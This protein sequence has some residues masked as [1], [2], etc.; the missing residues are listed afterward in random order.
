MAADSSK[1]LA[2]AARSATYN[3]V[4]QVIF[5][6]TTF[7]LNAF[8][9]RYIS[10]E[11]L[12]VVNVRL[13]LLYSTTLFVAR[14][15]FRKAC[16]SKTSNAKWMQII[17]LLW[18]TVLLGLACGLSLAYFWVYFLEVPNPETI[19][20]YSVGVVVY[21]LSA[22][23]EL[24]AEPLYVIAQV[25]LFVKL[26]VIVEGLAV[27]FRSVLTVI[28]VL[29]FPHWGIITFCWAQLAFTILYVV[30]YYAYFI[31]Y[32]KT[33]GDKSFPLK[34]TRDIFPKR[35]PGHKWTDHTLA[36]L[37]WSFFKQGFMKQ[38]LTEG[39]RYIM[40][41]FGTINFSEQGVYDII[42]NLGSLAARFI[43]FPLEDS[44]YLFFAQTLERGIPVKDQPKK[45]MDL[46]SKV[47]EYLLGFVFIIGLTIAVF[48]Y[49]YS[50][51]LLHLYG[52]DDLS[53]G[54]GPTLLRWYC[55]YV[56]LLSVNGV[57]E[58]FVFAAMT[59]ADVDR[60][61]HKL[62]V[63]SGIFMF[64]SWY[65]A[66]VLGSVGFILANCINIAVR[67]LHSIYYTLNYYKDTE[68]RP[69]KGIIPSLMVLVVY[70]LAL[71]I[72]A[73]SETKLCCDKGILF[74]L[75]HIAIGG[76][77]CVVISITVYFSEYDMIEFIAQ[78]FITR[79]KATSEKKIK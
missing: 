74:R 12:G 61:N 6:M 34:N 25:L 2:S 21:T 72:T 35:N 66:K 18:C 39:E 10:K 79:R 9:V 27:F 70:S 52:G 63:F 75:L 1:T 22:V 73:V 64:F 54:P 62:L 51:L 47:L 36:K 38:I 77:C 15:A 14:E 33:S 44:A 11:M 32:I 5:R 58:A 29:F 26:K 16:F 65:F 30:L 59:T 46:A 42:S 45:S 60:F 4:L 71:V 48:G 41:F 56:L 7:A 31:N 57:T 49:S 76:I 23:L 8:V 19:P 67:I 69:L 40:T 17:N 53:N 28:L 68:Y 3:M 50:H 20:N 37:T 78:Q 24:L 55:V 13:T 43:F